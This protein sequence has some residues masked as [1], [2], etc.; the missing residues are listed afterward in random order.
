MKGNQVDPT[1]TLYA[2]AG[3]WGTTPRDINGDNKW[4][5]E[6]WASKKYVHASICL[7]V[8]SFVYR[9][10]VNETSKIMHFVAIDDKGEIFDNFDRQ[11]S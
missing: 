7:I 4:Y 9:V 10:D 6:K 8:Y 2:G 5:L 3:T 11:I 1:G